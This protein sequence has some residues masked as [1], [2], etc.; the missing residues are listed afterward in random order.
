MWIWLES[1]AALVRSVTFL[2][3]SSDPVS[4]SS[5]PVYEE[6]SVFITVCMISEASTGNGY[7]YCIYIDISLYILRRSTQQAFIGRPE[8]DRRTPFSVDSPS[9]C[10]NER[11]T[12]LGSGFVKCSEIWA[13]HGTDTAHVMKA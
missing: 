4:P 10:E 12:R 1:E 8:S 2:T 9:L 3:W 5:Q 11:G 13:L 7:Y 6:S